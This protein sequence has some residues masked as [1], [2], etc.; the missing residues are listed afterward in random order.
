M[1]LRVLAEAMR[2][3]LFTLVAISFVLCGA[4]D[5]AHA[6]AH[7]LE[8]NGIAAQFVEIGGNGAD[9][10]SADSDTVSGHSCAHHGHHGTI[11]DVNDESSQFDK[12]RYV[13]SI[14]MMTSAISANI[15]RPPRA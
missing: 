7:E 9:D 2:S 13:I 12:S 10:R 4:V 8:E 3:F 6:D 11:I 5:A 14:E 15:S 1:S